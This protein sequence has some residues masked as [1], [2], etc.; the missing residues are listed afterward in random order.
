MKSASEDTATGGTDLRPIPRIAIQAFCETPEVASVIEAA[1]LDRR[2]SK[3]HVQVRMGGA[4]AAVDYF[5]SAPTPNLLMVEC[6]DSRDGVLAKLDT[7]SGVCDPG[8]KVIVI[9]HQNDVLLFRELLRRGVSDYM[10]VPFDLFDVIRE[11]AEIYLDPGT[12]PVGRTVGFVGARGGTGSSTIAH[13]VGFALSRFTG[14]DVVIADMDL[15]FGT[16]GLDF[17][18]DPPQGI[19]EA[20]YSQDRIDEVYL[21]RLMAKCS[22]RLS[23][24]AAPATL[25]RSYDFQPEAF[26]AIV[27]AARASV[28]TVVLDIPHMWTGWVRRTLETVDDVVVTVAPDLSSLRNAKNLV[29]HLKTLRPNDAPPRYVINQAGVPKR[30]ELKPEDFAKAFGYPPVAVIPFE[31]VLF[32]T[33]GNNGQMIVEVNAKSPVAGM[34]DTI[35]KSVSGRG[36]V[37]R[38]KKGA[39]APLLSKLQLGRRKSA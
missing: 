1:A 30:P 10:V 27:D 2:M 21:D 39:L 11:V 17:N 32:G 18:Q 3:A 12:G 8:T 20:V 16:A 37:Q 38:V 5:A 33:A 6:K 23:L 4:A 14:A 9:G 22:E 31:P 36:E 19:A 24:L 29:D 7:L 35:A 13:N 34:F 15:A 25:D 26:E 28:P